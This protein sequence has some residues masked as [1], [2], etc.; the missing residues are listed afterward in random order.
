[1]FA[2]DCL[3]DVGIITE[4]VEV[5][6][7]FDNIANAPFSLAP[8]THWTPT[9]LKCIFEVLQNLVMELDVNKPSTKAQV[10]RNK[11][12]EETF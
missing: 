3:A 7:E 4:G 6:N 2:T 11:L 5:L 10:L 9:N 8:F 1:M 12:Y